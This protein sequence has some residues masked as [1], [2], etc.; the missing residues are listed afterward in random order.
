MV[1]PLWSIRMRA[2]MTVGGSGPPSG[3]KT[4][5]I[6]GAE[7]LYKPSE[8]EGVTRR[9]LLRAMNHSRGKPDTVVITVERVR[10]RPI[11]I[12]LLPVST[13]GC[14]SPDDARRLVSRLLSNTGVSEKAIRSGL[15][16]VA[17]KKVMRGASLVFSGAGSRAE[18]DMERGVRVSRLGIERSSERALSRRLAKAGINT[19]TVKEALILASKVASCSGI[20]AELCVSDDPDYTTGYVASK[21]FGYVRIPN[22][23]HKGSLC[24]GRVFFISEDADVEHIINY[25]EKKPVIVQV[26]RKSRKAEVQKSRNA[27][28]RQ[29]QLN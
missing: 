22:I 26:N 23:K 3:K 17:G 19:T 21:K 5:H 18:P 7:G 29:R 15:R 27:T 20:V 10:E 24:G 8:I 11:I 1:S 2:S 16:I 28:E 12:P 14:G 25:L 6:S 13:E 4:V 9:Y